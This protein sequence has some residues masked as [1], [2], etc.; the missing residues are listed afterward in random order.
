MGLRGI[1]SLVIMG[2]AMVLVVTTAAAVGS[3]PASAPPSAGATTACPASSPA[4]LPRPSAPLVMPEDYRLQLLDS[5]WQQLS[6]NYVDP[7]MNG[8]DWPALHTAYAQRI[9]SAENAW[10]DYAILEEMV[11]LLKDPD[12]QFISALTLDSAPA[13]DPT[14]GGI[15]ILV[16]SASAAVPGG[17]LRVLYV[18]PGSP[19]LAAGIAP[20][21]LIV[22]VG[23]DPCPRPE[24]VRGPVDTVVTLLVQTPGQEPRTVVVSRQKI[25]PTYET[26]ATRLADAPGIGYLRLMSLTGDDVPAAV[27]TALTGLLDAGPLDGLVVDLRHTSQGAPGVTPRR[28]HRVSPPAC[29]GS[30][31]AV[32]L[33]RSWDTPGPPRT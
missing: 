7:G 33:A 4:P 1:G 15:G 29:W 27:T 8:L 23:D 17:G 2:A 14:Y 11:G 3:T 28:A 13:I 12:T 31:W 32:M 6:D 16:D 9:M 24:L 25:A 26:A 21:D 18:F 5:V 22:A 30:S 20:R 19:A 10:E